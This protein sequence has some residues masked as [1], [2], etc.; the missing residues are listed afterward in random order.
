MIEAMTR[1]TPHK[2]LWLTGT[3]LFSL[4]LLFTVT[5]TDASFSGIIKPLPD[6]FAP[7]RVMAVID[8]V[9]ANYN[10]FLAINLIH[11]LAGQ[12]GVYFDN[13]AWLSRQANLTYYLGMPKESHPV[14]SVAQQK[15]ALAGQVA[16][17]YT[18]Q[19]TKMADDSWV[20]IDRL[21]SVLIR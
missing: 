19:A 8:Q 15:L 2:V 14:F 3:A 10:R 1:E 5:V 20:S 7:S 13:L 17:A 12:Y 18:N 6:P 16:G 11:P 9:A 21:F 4:V